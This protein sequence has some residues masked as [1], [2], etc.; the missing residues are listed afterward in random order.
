MV[1][2]IIFHSAEKNTTESLFSD[3]WR[4][5]ETSAWLT[6]FFLVNKCFTTGCV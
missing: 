5:S 2:N 4:V 3:I 6:D 1:F